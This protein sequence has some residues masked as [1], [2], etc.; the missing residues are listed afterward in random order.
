M[1]FGILSDE[2]FS[3]ELEKANSNSNV[4]VSNPIEKGRGKNSEVPEV[5]REIVGELA[6]E[7]PSSV[8]S[9][10][11]KFGVSKSSISAYKNGATSTSSYHSPD[12]KLA[13]HIN[14]V[15]T[16]LAERAQRRLK[17]AL[18]AITADKI[19]A[20][21]LRDVSSLAKDMASV[22]EKM[23]PIQ[24]NQQNNQVNFVFYSPRER[25]EDSFEV[26]DVSGI[27]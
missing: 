13:E 6:T 9:I 3:K 27:E 2:D 17:S 18:D 21:R 12:T 16:R 10:S 26:I 14:G 19:Q 8:E 15:R 20:A 4:P 5:V 23:T 11:Q 7:S 22:I 1:P 24:T 25:K